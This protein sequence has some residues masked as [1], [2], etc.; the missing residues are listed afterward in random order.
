VK[1]EMMPPNGRTAAEN[2]YQYICDYITDGK[3]PD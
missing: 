1:N 3:R 2:V